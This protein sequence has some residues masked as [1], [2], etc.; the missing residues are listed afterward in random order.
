MR[1]VTL[2]MA[3]RLIK[4]SNGAVKSSPL[5]TTSPPGA[6]CAASCRALGTWRPQRDS[7]ARSSPPPQ[8]SVLPQSPSV[9]ARLKTHS[10]RC[11]PC[12]SNGIHKRLTD[13]RAGQRT[14][15]AITVADGLDAVGHGMAGMRIHVR[16]VMAMPHWGRF[17]IARPA[18]GMLK[19]SWP[20]LAQQRRPYEVS[21]IVVR[22][23]L[24]RLQ[25]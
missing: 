5:G 12:C 19:A 1:C 10:A 13:Q 2:C 17:S 7:Q 22:Q 9:P 11:Y 20:A 4:Q 8:P 25:I 18:S 24:K 6:L 15:E 16:A 21:W 3:H 14:A 23:S